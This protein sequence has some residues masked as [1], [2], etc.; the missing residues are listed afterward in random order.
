[1]RYGVAH[2]GR[3]KGKIRTALGDRTSLDAAVEVANLNKC[4]VAWRSKLLTMDRAAPSVASRIDG[5]SMSLVGISS[6]YQMSNRASRAG[7]DRVK[8]RADSSA[9]GS[10]LHEFGVRRRGGYEAVLLNDLGIRSARRR[11]FNQTT[12]RH[13]RFRPNR[14]C[15]RNCGVV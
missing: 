11:R 9:N 1:M 14:R 2:A 3:G 4:L 6:W 7:L 15:H 8:G 12:V 10:L 5:V 13:R